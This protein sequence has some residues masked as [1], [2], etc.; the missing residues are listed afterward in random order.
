M[1]RI[2]R[3]IERNRP[4]RAGCGINGGETKMKIERSYE[5]I[6]RHAIDFVVSGQSGC[7]PVSCGNTYNPFARLI[8][9]TVSGEAQRV[10]ARSAGAALSRPNCSV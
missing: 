5:Q 8:S 1:R 9:S 2:E 3:N 10:V 4:K 7:G 6:I